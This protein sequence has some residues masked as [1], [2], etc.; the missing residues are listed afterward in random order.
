MWMCGCSNVWSMKNINIWK[1]TLTCNPGPVAGLSTTARHAQC[2]RRARLV[3]QFTGPG[4]HCPT[5]SDRCSL[6]KQLLPTVITSAG[7]RCSS[8]D[9]TKTIVQAFVISYNTLCDGVTNE[10]TQCLKLVQNATTRLVTGTRRGDVIISH[11][12]C[13]S[14]T[15][16]VSGSVS[17]SRLQLSSTGSWLATPWVTW[18]TTVSSS[19]MPVSDNCILPTLEHSSVGYP[20]VLETGPL[21]LQDQKSGKVCHPI[22]DC[23]G[24]HTARHFYTDSEAMAQCAQF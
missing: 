1:L 18:C 20:A 6:S 14:C 21:P 10:Q 23:V 13:A 19:P 16:I 8:E 22:S 17:C 24:C 3:I 15:G 2:G 11:L 4:C 5:T 9:T 7:C 12:C